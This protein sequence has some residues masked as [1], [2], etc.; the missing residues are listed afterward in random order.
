MLGQYEK[1]PQIVHGI[2]SFTYKF[3]AEKLQ[4]VILQVFYELNRETYDL[5]NITYLPSS[6][7]TV[8]FEIGI[9]EDVSFNFL[10]EEELGRFLK[11]VQKNALQFL[12]FFCVARYH[13]V[14]KDEKR[15]PLKFDHYFLRF[16]F[17]QRGMELRIVHER[18]T[19]HIP[20]EDLIDFVVK[21][22]N[23]KLIER[24]LEPLSKR[25]LRAL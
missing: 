14:K 22:I 25:Y 18:G 20:L 13:V 9:A 2:A 19:Q 5:S 3:S 11:W 21:Q 24:K 16:S 17:Y 23:R 4:R 15:V 12:D 8:S 1:F 6:Q 10:D 7:C